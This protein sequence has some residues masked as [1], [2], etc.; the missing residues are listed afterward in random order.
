MHGT[1]NGVDL[2]QITSRHILKR[3]GKI[4]SSFRVLDGGAKLEAQLRLGAPA[5]LILSIRDRCSQHREVERRRGPGLRGR[6]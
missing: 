3:D 1:F 4:L 5:L 2:R 6:D